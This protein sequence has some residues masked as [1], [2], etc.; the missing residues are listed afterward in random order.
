MAP[1]VYEMNAAI[2]IWKRKSLFSESP[3]LKKTSL[4]KMPYER[5]IDI[6]SALDLKMVKFF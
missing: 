3:F 5:S 4:Y 6:D 2:Y 1:V